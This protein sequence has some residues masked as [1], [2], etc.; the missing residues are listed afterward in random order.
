MLNKRAVD[1]V[2]DANGE[3]AGRRAAV[4][5][6]AVTLSMAA[7]ATAPD[8]RS[9]RAIIAAEGMQGLKAAREQQYVDPWLRQEPDD[10]PVS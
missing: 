6:D 3:S 2:A 4:A 7:H 8:G 5:H 1:A 9:F 10:G